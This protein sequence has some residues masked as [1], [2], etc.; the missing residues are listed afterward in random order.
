MADEA[1]FSK[2]QGYVRPKEIVYRDELSDELRQPIIDIIQRAASREVLRETI[3]RI[4]NPYGLDAIPTRDGPMITTDEE[5]HPIS[6]TLSAYCWRVNGSGYTICWRT[7]SIR[8]IFTI[9]T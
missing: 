8:C 5:V 7:F 3:N 2:R 1:P 6:S 4:F 9:R